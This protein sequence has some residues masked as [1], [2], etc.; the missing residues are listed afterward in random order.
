GGRTMPITKSPAPAATG[1]RGTRN[2]LRDTQG[3]YTPSQK[4]VPLL[5]GVRKTG[6]GLRADC[7]NGHSKAKG[8]LAITESDDG[9]LLMHCFACADT[10]GIMGALGL[11]L[12]DLYP[13]PIKDLSP[14]G[15]RA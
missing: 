12:G 9:R 15:R 5:N 6:T 11:E 2:A 10:A 14:E 3:H 4:I 1:D 13:E 8:S 7:P